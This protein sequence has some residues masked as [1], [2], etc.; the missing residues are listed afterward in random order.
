VQPTADWHVIA[1][2]IEGSAMT[3][4]DAIFE[5]LEVTKKYGLVSDYLV[6]WSG[7]AG[8]LDAKVTVWGNGT[9]SQDVVQ[10][11]IAQLLRGLVSSRQINVAAE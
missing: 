9:A 7:Q 3:N 1:P 10:D 4:Q 5:R 11:Y 2:A 8:H 6:S